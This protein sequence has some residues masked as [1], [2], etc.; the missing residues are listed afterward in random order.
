MDTARGERLDDLRELQAGRAEA[1]KA[2]E[3]RAVPDAGTVSVAATHHPEHPANRAL[4][5]S[6]SPYATQSR[7]LGKVIFLDGCRKNC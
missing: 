3:L 6:P 1:L 4:P 7:F 2:L 5:A